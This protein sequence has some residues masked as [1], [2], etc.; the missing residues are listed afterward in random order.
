MVYHV[1]ALVPFSVSSVNT[2]FPTWV[3]RGSHFMAGYDPQKNTLNWSYDLLTM[4]PYEG[5]QSFAHGEFLITSYLDMRR[6]RQ[7]WIFAYTPED[8]QVVWQQK[9]HLGPTDNKA[10]GNYFYQTE[11]YIM[12]PGNDETVVLDAQTGKP[13]G[14]LP[15]INRGNAF[16]AGNYTYVYDS[17]RFVRIPWDV[18]VLPDTWEL[19]SWEDAPEWQLF[20]HAQVAH[21]FVYVSSFVANGDE[22]TMFRVQKL[23]ADS[24]E[25]LSRLELPWKSERESRIVV[26]PTEDAL[27]A[28]HPS[29]YAYFDF[30]SETIRW[31]REWDES[32][33]VRWSKHGIVA[34]TWSTED[35][36]MDPQSGELSSTKLHTRYDATLQGDFLITTNNF[37]NH[38]TWFDNEDD[39]TTERKNVSEAIANNN[40]KYIQDGFATI[41]EW[42]EGEPEPPRATMLLQHPVPLDITEQLERKT[43]PEE[44]AAQEINIAF[45]VFQKSEDVEE[46]C[47]SLRKIMGLRR[48]HSDVKKFFLQSLETGE[49]S[50]YRHPLKSFTGAEHFLTYEQIWDFGPKDKLFPGLYSIGYTSAGHEFILMLESGQVLGLHHDER[51]ELAWDLNK[52][53]GDLMGSEPLKLSR[54]LSKRFGQGTLG[55]WK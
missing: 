54:L 49:Q 17:D 29:G 42:K 6:E 30:Q 10:R 19:V 47:R 55:K 50:Q 53:E 24:F 45:R 15:Y 13:V 4:H 39:Y 12:Y 28:T 18:T 23:D 20:S 48:I 32:H 1:K 41:Y 40:V 52:D 8:G 33:T 43:F 37:Y 14:R 9:V 26:S 38:R 51:F 3:L 21:D 5:Y 16:R 22:P 27:I 31:Q 34:H 2:D 7:A 44:A 11:R 25:E 35:F 36:Q 46:F